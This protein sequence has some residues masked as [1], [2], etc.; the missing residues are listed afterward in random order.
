VPRVPLRARRRARAARTPPPPPARTSTET[1]K[2]QGIN[3]SGIIRCSC[4]VTL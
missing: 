2:D 3:C 4:L 1:A